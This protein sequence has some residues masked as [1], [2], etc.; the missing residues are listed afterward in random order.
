[1][2]GLVKVLCP[3]NVDFARMLLLEHQHRLCDCVVV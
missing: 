1:M 3:G 2:G